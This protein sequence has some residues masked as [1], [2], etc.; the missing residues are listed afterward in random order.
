MKDR[1][2]TI[3]RIASHAR[4]IFAMLVI[5]GCVIDLP[6]QLMGQ[7]TE[8][9]A[10]NGT[11]TDSQ[12]RVV[13]GAQVIATNIATN[14][15]QT[16]VTNGEGVYRIF[17]LLPAQYKVTFTA[18]GFKTTA[19]APFKLDVGQTITQNAVLTVGTVTEQVQVNAQQ[20]LLETTT[21]ENSTTI[22]SQQMND[23]PLNGRSYTGLIALTPGANGTRINGQFGDGNRYVLDGANNTTLLGA[24]SAYVPNL[25]IIQE[26]SIDSQSSKAEEGGFLGATVSAAT[27][28]GTNQFHGDA[29]EFG[30][31]NKFQARNPLSNLP[32]VPLPRYHLNQYGATLGGPILVPKVY[33][34]RNKTFFFFGYQRYTVIQQSQAYSRVPTTDELNGI[35]TNSL[36]FVASPN[37][38]HLYDP[39]TTSGTVNPTRQPFANDVIPPGRINTLTQAYL[40]LMLPAPNFTPT[41]S[42]PTSN[43]YDLFPSPSI[44]ND[45]S[46]RLDHRVGAR[47]N[48]WGRFSLVNNAATTYTNQNIARV[49][50]SNRKDLTVDWV[51]IFSPRLFMESNYSYQL[52]PTVIDNT[53]P[54]GG[55]P[56]NSIVGLG[57]SAAQIQA[58]GI[59]DFAG[60]GASTPGL[61][62]HYEQGQHVPFS[63]NESLSL[64]LGKHTAKFGI[65]LSHK[66]YANIS[67]GHHFSY[68]SIQTEDPNAADPGAGN[69]GQG[70][71]S[72]LLGLPASVSI[73]NGDYAEA[74]L[75]WAIYAEDSWKVRPDLT[76]SAGLRYDNF[77]TPNF[78]QGIINDWDANTGIYYI[79]GGKTPPACSASPVAPCIPGTGNIA[80]LPN[81]NMI[82][83]AKNAGIMNPIHDNWGPRIGI[84]WNVMHA[85]VLRAGFGIYFDPESNTTQEDQNTFGS[86]P[87]STNLN[88]SYNAIGSS[89][90][91]INSI[92]GLALSPVTTGVP[93][94]QSSYFWD[95]NK[96]NPKS[97]QWNVDIQRQFGKNLASTISYVG[98]LGTRQDMTLD[99]NASQ[100]PGP[101]NAAVIN[102]LRK[103]PFYGADTH[104]GTDL[105]RSNYNALQVKVVKNYSNNISLLASYTWSKLMDNNSAGWYSGAPQNA[106]NVNADYGLS[107]Q[108]RTQMFAAAATYQ[109]PFGKGQMWLQNGVAGAVLGNWQLNVIGQMRSG[110]PVS[111]IATGDPANIGNTAYNY[112]RPNL[113]GNPHVSNPS[114]K[115]WLNPAAFQ[116]PVYAFGNAGRGLIRNPNF[117]NADISV[118]KNIPMSKIEEKLALQLR[119][120]AFNALN[121]ITRGNVNGTFTNNAQFGQITSIGSSPRQLQFAVKL[122]F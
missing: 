115:G 16:A 29:W 12:E 30:R 4:R 22:E 70:L 48:I 93:W 79:G 97:E 109:L 89:A 80:D 104:F 26:F 36:F 37:Q 82:Q 119:V 25:D 5:L 95:P 120:E 92:D 21:V 20:Q 75:N 94:G 18:Q 44:I 63:L 78:T 59:P 2:S 122:Y 41:A 112:D 31:N 19:V 11:V 52:F 83:V 56:T 99:A 54:S 1:T 49:Q 32:G 17:N 28:S 69:T 61:I 45:Y 101:G 100:T 15:A 91:S 77:P 106:Y 38:V 6:H 53:F 81:G 24:S 50:T 111:I 33:N 65:N 102:S 74:Y 7:A 105:G 64:S 87:S 67:L 68:S 35:F 42:F 96:K 98:N 34:G 27:K 90:T 76:I 8:F 85:T 107:N 113:I 121:L 116:Q 10:L 58:Y 71:A 86:W 51:H 108:D 110:V 39:A 72:A 117:Q 55:D 88:A 84:A 62:G 40:K 23:L 60:T 14:V 47:D 73:S 43:R 66:Q 57:F 46:I 13:T 9:G 103:F 3:V 118:F 114:T